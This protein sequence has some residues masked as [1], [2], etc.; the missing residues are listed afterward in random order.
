MNVIIGLIGP[1]TNRQERCSPVKYAV[2]VTLRVNP[3]CM[4]TFMALMRDNAKTSLASEPGCLQFDICTDPDC[5]DEV[6]LYEI[7]ETRQAFEVHLKSEHF[8]SFD[9]HSGSLV[10]EKAVKTYR[11]VN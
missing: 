11:M 6:F 4:D 9:R 1:Q 8:Q 7:Y 10:S 2:C 5:P 3:G